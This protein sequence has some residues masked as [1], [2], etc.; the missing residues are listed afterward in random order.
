MNIAAKHAGADESDFQGL[1]HE[2][3]RENN[4]WRMTNDERP[5]AG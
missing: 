2:R 3:E 4:E 1:F 5:G